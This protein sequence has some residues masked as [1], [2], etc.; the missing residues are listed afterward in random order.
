MKIDAQRTLSLVAGLGFVAYACVSWVWGPGGALPLSALTLLLAFALGAL[1][2]QVIYEV[3]WKL[4]CAAVALSACLL[5]WLGV[6][7]NYVGAALALG[8]A[9]AIGYK[10]WWYTP[11][12]AVGLVA[13]GS[14]GSIF[15]AGVAVLLGFGRRYPT[16]AA[17]V[18]LSAIALCLGLRSFDSL[19]ARLGIWQDTLN[20]LTFWGHGLGSFAD[21]YA[22]LEVKRNMTLTLAPHA[23]DDFLELV[24]ELGIGSALLW[25][26]LATLSP[27]PEA[28][29]ILWTF[30]AL[31]LTYFPLWVPGVGH[32]FMFTLGYVWSNPCGN[33]SSVRPLSSAA[34]QRS[35]SQ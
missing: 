18:F 13:S 27:G 8:L 10:W 34:P 31:S 1:A 5:L 25:L 12:A 33:T 32:L 30:F 29:L 22:S 15:G 20:G 14:R 4:S 19:Y 23:Y 35:L 9:A 17:C 26:W 6:N 7:P 24:F 2:S 28:R 3:L 21:W 16:T 11:F